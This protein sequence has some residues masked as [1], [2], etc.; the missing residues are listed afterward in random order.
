MDYPKFGSA[1]L[2]CRSALK[3][4]AAYACTVNPECTTIRA[5]VVNQHSYFTLPLA[6]P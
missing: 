3:D 6:I 1:Y 5:R 4:G 2:Y